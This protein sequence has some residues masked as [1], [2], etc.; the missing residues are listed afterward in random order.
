MSQNLL[1]PKIAKICPHLFDRVRGKNNKLR[2][3]Q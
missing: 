2:I 1:S 3:F